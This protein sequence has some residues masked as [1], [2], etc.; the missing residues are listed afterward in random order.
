MLPLRSTDLCA[1]LGALHAIGEES[2]AGEGFARRGIA[3]LR[4]LVAGELTTLSICNLDTGHRS[5][6]SDLPGALSRRACPS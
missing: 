2:G 3:S 1:C 4:R 5:V 6:V